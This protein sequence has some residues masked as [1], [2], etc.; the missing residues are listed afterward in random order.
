MASGKNHDKATKVLS[1][2]FVLALTVFLGLGNGLIG[3]LSFLIGGLWLS[4]DLDT[5]SNAFKRWGPLKAIWIPYQKI[6][7][8][9]SVLSHAPLIGTTLRLLYLGI[10][11]LFILKILKQFDLITIEYTIKNMLGEI[12]LHKDSSLAIILGLETSAWLHL[13]QD[14]D[15]LLI[16]FKK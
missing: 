10:W 6:V 2:P 3:G 5:K 9:R 12:F 15:P 7:P 8:H 14:G 11:S 4:P 16:K 1:I 13:L